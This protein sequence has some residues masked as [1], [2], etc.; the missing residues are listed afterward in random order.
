MDGIWIRTQDRKGLIYAQRIAIESFKEWKSEEFK[1]RIVNQVLY[2][3]VANDYD[4][5]GVYDTEERAI[6]VLDSIQN[7]IM[8]H[9]LGD[10]INPVFE[11]PKA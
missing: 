11:M 9:I 3:D 5:L 1:Y 2:Q 8:A 4:L 10:M 7:I 6:E